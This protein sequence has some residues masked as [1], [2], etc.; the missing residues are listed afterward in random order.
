MKTPSSGRIHGLMESLVNLMLQFVEAVPNRMRRLAHGGIDLSKLRMDLGH[1]G[2]AFH[3]H[4]GS[5]P[6]PETAATGLCPLIGSGPGSVALVLIRAVLGE[7][8]LAG[9]VHR[10]ICHPRSKRNLEGQGT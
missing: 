9:N 7:H 10:P 4:L 2:Y 3:P 6:A 1:Q 8:D 5:I